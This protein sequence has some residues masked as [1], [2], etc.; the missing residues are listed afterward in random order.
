MEACL[1]LLNKP[2]LLDH[3]PVDVFQTGSGTSSNMNANEVIAT[4]AGK[5]ANIAVNPN[6]H[7]N[8][9]Q[10]SNDIIPTSIH[11]SAVLAVNGQLIPS[12]RH[13]I[14]TIKRKAE[15][16]KGYCDGSHAL[17]GCNACENG[18]E[19]AWLG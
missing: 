2:D 7:V 15:R 18:P 5:I 19:P 12:L 13:A 9:G 11:V 14:E 16:L 3:F 17:D 10:S 6:D 4:L 8:F 1:D